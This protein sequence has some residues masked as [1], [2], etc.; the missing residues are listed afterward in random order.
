MCPV[1]SCAFPAGADFPS[2]GLMTGLE[3]RCMMNKPAVCSNFARPI[4]CQT[5]DFS[6]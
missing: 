3:G 6:V 1:P 2:G 4:F 5:V